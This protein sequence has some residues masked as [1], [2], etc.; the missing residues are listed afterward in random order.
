MAEGGAL[1]R[2]YRGITSVEGS[3]PSFSVSDMDKRSPGHRLLKVG[4][5][6]VSLAIVIT[7]ERDL[8]RRPDDEIR[9]EKRLWRVASLNALGAL[10]YLRWGRRPRT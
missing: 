5:L 8:H 7:A 1:L 6:A 3:N 2:R 4:L 9:G 10:A